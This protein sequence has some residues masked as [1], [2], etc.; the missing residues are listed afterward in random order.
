METVHY[1]YKKEYLPAEENWC[2]I[3]CPS[4]GQFFSWN[5]ITGNLNKSYQIVDVA[6][7]EPQIFKTTES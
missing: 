3:C 6:I 7:P 2:T 1:V 4:R 5:K